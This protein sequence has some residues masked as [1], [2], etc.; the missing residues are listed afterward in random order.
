MSDWRYP[1]TLEERVAVI[2]AA[3]SE[4]IGRLSTFFRK[5][6][7][8][9]AHCILEDG[10]GA[11]K[12]RLGPEAQRYITLYH[13]RIERENPTAEIRWRPIPISNGGST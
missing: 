9:I 3:E 4:S 6:P 5:Q 2:E 10:S 7:H 8:V 11:L 12:R 13:E 1:L